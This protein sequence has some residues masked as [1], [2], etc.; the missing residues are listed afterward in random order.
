[1]ELQAMGRDVDWICIAEWKETSG[2]VACTWQLTFG[3]R[4]VLG[5][6]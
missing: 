6:S 2:R 4:A 3:L 5:I 1:M